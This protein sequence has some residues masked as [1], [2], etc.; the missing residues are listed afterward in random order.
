MKVLVTGANGFVGSNLCKSLIQS[1]QTVVGLVRE[2]SDLKFLED[3]SALHIIKGDITEK[4]SLIAGMKDVAVVYHAA[5]YVSDWGFWENFRKANVEGV[6]NVMEAA[7]HCSVNRVVHISSVSVYGLPGGV[8]IDENAPLVS[9]PDDPYITTKTEGEK[10]ALSYNSDRLSVTVIR[11]A[12]VYGPNDRITTLQLVPAILNRQFGYVDGGK[13]ILAPVYIDNLVQMII[14][15]GESEKAANQ[16]YN[17]VDDDKITWKQYI[18]WMCEDLNCK[19]PWLST[20][21]WIAWPLAVLIDNFAKLLNKKESP[22]INIYR[23][24]VV[25]NDNH[26]STE[27]AKK[28]LGYCPEVS[29]REGIKRTVQWYLDYTG[30][31]KNGN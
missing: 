12:G 22:M 26:Y 17:A 19:T 15:A 2:S 28:E 5:G 31:K 7:L 29:T 4:D 21:R 11:P 10:L 6:R 1:G 23:V 18:E 8:D 27:K 30:Q 3:L 25:M 9:R 14:L 24:R 20:P 16:I 13:H